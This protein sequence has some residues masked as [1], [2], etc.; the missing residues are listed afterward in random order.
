MKRGVPNASWLI[1]KGGYIMAM[2]AWISGILGGRCAVWGI[3]TA[4]DILPE[5]AVI[6]EVAGFT[7]MFWMALGGI[8]FIAAIAFT[9]GRGGGSYE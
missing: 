6:P 5:E 7:W 9:V 4:V 8:L 3:I 1:N 2:S